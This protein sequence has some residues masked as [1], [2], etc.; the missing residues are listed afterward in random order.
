[1]KEMVESDDKDG[2]GLQKEMEKKKVDHEAHKMW[3]KMKNE[4]VAELREKGIDVE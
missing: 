2:A 3:L 1:V 4:V